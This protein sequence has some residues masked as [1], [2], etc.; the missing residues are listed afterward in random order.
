MTVGRRSAL[1]V[2]TYE[3][4]DASLQQL[5]A[6]GHDVEALANL[7]ADPEVAGFDVTT[8]INEPHHVVGDAIGTFY[9]GLRRDD[10]A[11]LYITGHGLKD[12][13]GRLF[14]AMTNSR[15]TGLLFTAIGAEQ[16]NDA[17]NSCSSRQKVLILDC[18]YGGAFPGGWTAKGGP[19]VD[20]IERFQGRGRV[21]LTASDAAQYSFEGDNLSGIGS[22][23]LFTRYLIEGIRTGKA[24]LD[25]DGDISLDELY[26]YVH[27]RVIEEMP[28]QRPKKQEDVEGRIVIAKNVGWQMP[29]YVQNAINSP[30]ALDRRGAIQTLSHLYRVGNQTVRRQALEQLQTLVEDDSRMVSG[31]AADVIK[32]LFNTNRPPPDTQ[33]VSDT[34]TELRS[35]E[36][37]TTDPDGLTTS[38][39]AV[40]PQAETDQGVDLRLATPAGVTAE[41][42]RNHSAPQPDQ[43]IPGSDPAFA[44]AATAGQIPVDA[45][46]PPADTSES[47][48]SSDRAVGTSTGAGKWRRP[49]MAAALAVV[50][51][52]GLV[53]AIV[54]LSGK[55]A[56]RASAPASA[57]STVQVS[58]TEP[59]TDTGVDCGPGEV[60]DISATGTVL[61]NKDSADSTVSPDGLTDPGYRQYNVAGLPD[62]NTVALIGSFDRDQPFFV[63]GSAKT[64]TCP[65][66]GR[67]FLGVNDTGLVGLGGNSGEFSATI[68]RQ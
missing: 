16:I 68:T 35:M 48:I 42:T 11:L 12:D 1:L 5:A 59:W 62:A 55:D 13:K 6:P 24:D 2:G 26:S 45:T 22:S 46:V 30:I 4:V 63:V 25:R 38:A 57:T 61:H 40:S 33:T 20:S 49:L 7:L 67:L 39:S 50:V 29:P 31:D 36:A 53:T 18:C 32:T 44:D 28:Q 19:D 34:A 56:D 65:A 51:I 54:M 9:E 27:D 66:V 17:M 60:L 14:L 3:Y 47:I 43:E 8:L 23:S 10:L 64:I 58:S 41:E 37:A 52:A 15:R 21:V